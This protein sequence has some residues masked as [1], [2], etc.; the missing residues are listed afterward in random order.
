MFDDEVIRSLGVRFRKN[1][2]VPDVDQVIKIEERT[3]EQANKYVRENDF[4]NPTISS[5]ARK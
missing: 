3:R 5:G 1:K 2:I 4:L